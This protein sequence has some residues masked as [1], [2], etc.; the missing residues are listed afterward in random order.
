[1]NNRI[2]GR[3]HKIHI[4]KNARLKA[5]QES[6]RDLLTGLINKGYTETYIIK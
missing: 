5:Y 6:K 1:M 3:V 4:E 2:Y